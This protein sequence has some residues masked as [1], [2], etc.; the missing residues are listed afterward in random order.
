VDTLKSAEKGTFEVY[1]LGCTLQSP[2]FK[3]DGMMAHPN[4]SDKSTTA[5]PPELL[6]LVRDK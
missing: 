5:N 4:F 2:V 1:K 6:D 3:G